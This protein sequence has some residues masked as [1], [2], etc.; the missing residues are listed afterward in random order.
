MGPIYSK[1]PLESRLGSLC[2]SSVVVIPSKKLRFP[3]YLLTFL[4]V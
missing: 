4:L 3:H 2:T 1:N